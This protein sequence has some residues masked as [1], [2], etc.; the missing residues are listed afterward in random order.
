MILQQ[1]IISKYIT[2]TYTNTPICR[3]PV[4]SSHNIWIVWLCP[5]VYNKFTTL[6]DAKDI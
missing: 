4:G 2:N 6:Q 1:T 3:W 5:N